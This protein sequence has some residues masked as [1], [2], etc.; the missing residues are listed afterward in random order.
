MTELNIQSVV[1]PAIFND[2]MKGVTL[3]MTPSEMEET[4]GKLV[5]LP[6]GLEH[7]LEGVPEEKVVGKV[8]ESWVDYETAA[9]DVTKDRT[10]GT[11]KRVW[12][13]ISLPGDTKASRSA[14]EGP[15]GAEAPVN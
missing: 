7:D 11:A 6:V 2:G 10:K 12:V 5:G 9:G 3:T 13:N 1:Q 15:V 8:T 4:A 14:I